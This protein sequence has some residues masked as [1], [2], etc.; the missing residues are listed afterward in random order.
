MNLP[1]RAA[2][3]PMLAAILL[4]GAAGSASAF[5]QSAPVSSDASAV[6]EAE[7]DRLVKDVSAELRCVVCQGLS[8]EDSPSGLAQ[9][10]RGVVR[11][12]LAAG[13]TP[14]QVK[15]YFVERY[16]EW[17]LLRPKASGM[18]LIVYLLPI[19]MIAG[20]AVV[21]FVKARSWTRA[22]GERTA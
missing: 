20:G 19:A 13:R 15:A 4:V 6:Q 9:E 2:L 18:N 10:M 1:T 5:A 16:G 21:I 7:L 11:E 14:E 3:L 22:T 8:I 12:Q 17:V